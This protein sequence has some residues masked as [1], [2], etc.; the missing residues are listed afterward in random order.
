[1]VELLETV[2]LSAYHAKRH[3]HEFS[4][5]QRQ[6]INIARAL[7]LNPDI[8]VCDEPVS[9][10][11]VSVQAQVINLLKDLQKEF[12]LTY[13]FISHDLNVVN[14][15]CDRIAVMYLGKIVE[16]GTYK[17]IY[18]N[19]QHPYTQ[20][21]LSAIPKENPLIKRTV[22]FYLAM[23][24]ARLIPRV[25]VHS[26]SVVVLLQKNVQRSNRHL[27]QYQLHIKY[28]VIYISRY[29]KKYHQFNER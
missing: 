10:L 26:I 18:K 19:P 5:G 15:M 17:E 9:A 1:M 7:A 6:R 20:A 21:L 28:R 4:G 25:A 24:Q 3:P 2:G 11:D 8:V 12:G 27:I 23:F 13:I 29:S 14:Y 16:I 22:L